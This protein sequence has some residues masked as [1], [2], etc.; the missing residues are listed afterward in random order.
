MTRLILPALTIITGLQRMHAIVSCF[1]V[2]PSGTSG[3][4][5]MRRLQRPLNAV[6]P[7]KKDEESSNSSWEE[8]LQGLRQKELIEEEDQYVPSP[9]EDELQLMIFKR[10]LEARWRSSFWSKPPRFLPYDKCREWAIAQNMWTDKKEWVEW[11]AQGEMKPSVVP[12]NPE[13]YY[14]QFDTWKGWNDFLGIVKEDA[15]D[16]NSMD[17][18]GI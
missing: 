3:V 4:P 8:D 9:W 2:P 16:P 12:S 14:R 7:N 5:S 15:T 1:T 6:P 10:K 17:G 13:R 18:A 11:I